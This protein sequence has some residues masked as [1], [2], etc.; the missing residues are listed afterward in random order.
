MISLPGALYGLRCTIYLYYY[1][2]IVIV[3]CS[4]FYLFYPIV[5][6]PC[7]TL[8]IWRLLS[9]PMFDI[10]RYY[11]LLVL[12]LSFRLLCSFFTFLSTCHVMCQWFLFWLFCPSNF[13]CRS[14][15]LS[16]PVE[17]LWY[18]HQM[19]FYCLVYF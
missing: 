16:C 3:N 17:F 10:W 6:S 4:L 9:L 19:C 7:C 2:V 5:I 12:V 18:I 13:D 8:W 15:F 11:R 1:C 14:S